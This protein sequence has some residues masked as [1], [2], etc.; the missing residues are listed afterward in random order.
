MIVFLSVDRAG[1]RWT[2]TTVV[3]REAVGHRAITHVVVVRA[4]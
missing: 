2:R 3:L 1:A 4:A